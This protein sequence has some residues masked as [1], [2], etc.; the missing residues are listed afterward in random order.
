MLFCSS[1]L[2][3][4]SSCSSLKKNVNPPRLPRSS[5]SFPQIQ[6]LGQHL[7]KFIVNQKLQPHLGELYG[8]QHIKALKSCKLDHDDG[9]NDKEEK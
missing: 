4:T 9:N 7:G 2:V 1:K 5:H 3:I 6:R 8:F